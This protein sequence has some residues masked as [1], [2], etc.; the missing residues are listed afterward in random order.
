ML[1]RRRA[2]T[3]TLAETVP[4]PDVTAGFTAE[5]GIDVLVNTVAPYRIS[6]GI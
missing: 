1:R 6:S 2:P 3:V 4:I 5:T